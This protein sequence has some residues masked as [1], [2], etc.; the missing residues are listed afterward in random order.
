MVARRAASVTA[1]V[2][3]DDRM[4]LVASAWLHDIGYAEPLKRFSFHPLDGVSTC[5]RRP[6]AHG[7]PA[8]WPTTSA[9]ASSPPSAG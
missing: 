2:P 7:W 4:A 8:S 5:W 9:P 3:D 1:A 6:G